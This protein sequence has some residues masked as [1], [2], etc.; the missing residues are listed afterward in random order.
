MR[1]CSG[2]TEMLLALERGEFGPIG[3]KDG[4]VELGTFATKYDSASGTNTS[5]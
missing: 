1:F 2:E 4:F 5:L 3:V